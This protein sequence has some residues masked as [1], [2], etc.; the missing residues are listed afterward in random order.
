MDVEG[1]G[2]VDTLLSEPGNEAGEDGTTCAGAVVSEV[3]SSETV[4]PY[5]A[6]LGP[7]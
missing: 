6:G 1:T 4:C 5:Q 3:A 2:S 7:L